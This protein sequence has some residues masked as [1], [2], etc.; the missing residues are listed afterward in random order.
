MSSTL[1]RFLLT[2]AGNT[3]IAAFLTALGVGG[4][5]A[6]NL[7][8]SQCI[9]LSIFGTCTVA[10]RLVGEGPLRGAAVIAAAPV[11]VAIGLLLGVTLSGV[12]WAD[13]PAVAWQAVTIG[14]TLGVMGSGFFYLRERN[15]AL[16]AELQQR[17]NRRLEAEKQGLAAQLRMLQAQIEPHFLFNSLANVAALVESDPKLAGTLLDALIRYLRSSL[18][19]TRAEGGT[20]GDE[21]ALLTAFLDVLKIRM[22]RR[23]A[24]SFEILP[25]LLAVPFPPMLLQPLVENAVRHG[26]EPKVAGGSI[27]VSARRQGDRL[28]LVVRDDGLGFADMPGAGIGVANIR[29]RLLALYGSGGRL[30]MAPGVGGG[31]TATLTLPLEGST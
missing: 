10:G 21:V 2:L 14:T 8:V 9:G 30:E 5:W 20:L 26:L 22:G 29:A 11:G 31:V 27:V 4:G 16:A 1:H 23:L 7:L 3:L 12:G 25:E 6:I 17:E 19:R 13:W 24:Y 28:Q 18:T 15:L